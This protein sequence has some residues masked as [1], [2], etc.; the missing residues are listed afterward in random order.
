M[1]QIPRETLAECL[2][3]LQQGLSVE[4]ILSRFPEDSEALRP[5]LETAVRL[6]RLAHA[7]TLAATRRSRDTVLQEVDALG[8]S[9]GLGAPL[10]L[11]LRQALAPAV[12][13]A[14]LLLL[15]AVA[16]P[17][18]SASALPGDSLY[19]GKRL[20]ER[21]QLVLAS[22]PQQRAT[23]LTRFNEERIREV[24]ALLDSGRQAEVQFEGQIA[25]VETGYWTVAGI[26]VNLSRE[27]TVEGAPWPGAR[28]RVHGR[29]QDG[30][31]LARRL[32]VFGDPPPQPEPTLTATPSPTATP[33]G[34]ASPSPTPTATATVTPTPAETLEPLP[35]LTPAP[36]VSTSAPPAPS[37]TSDDGDDDNDND[38]DDTNENDDDNQNEGGGDDD[39][40]D[41]DDD[42]DNEND[43]G[44]DDDGGDDDDDDLNEDDDNGNESSDD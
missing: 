16:L 39:G 30:R 24:E 21:A 38:D 17:Q 9:R 20:V 18:I 36:P 6:S 15:F 41:N 31:L 8:E 10:W 34:A 32:V 33:T 26:R 1:K 28:A 25:E 13:F 7:P 11:W 44:G 43:N 37:P 27:T 40:N 3:L 4:Q 23:L 35:S 22:G 2:D 12:A 14:V 29:T 5:F 42:N 19:A